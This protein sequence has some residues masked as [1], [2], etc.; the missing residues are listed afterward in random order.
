VR[1]TAAWAL[2]TI[3]VPRAVEALTVRLEDQDRTVRQRAIGALAQ[4]CRDEIDQTLLSYRL[5]TGHPFLDPRT[6][7]VSTERVRKAA[8][9]LK[10]SVEEVQR[11]FDVL[12]ELFHFRLAWRSEPPKGNSTAPHN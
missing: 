1:A 8:E 6:A 12:A 3:K 4:L 10:L 7:E 2:G 5:N 11:R 9:I